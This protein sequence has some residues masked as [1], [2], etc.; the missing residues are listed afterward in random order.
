MSFLDD[1]PESVIS[2]AAYTDVYSSVCE[3]TC[4]MSEHED[5][6][7][8]VSGMTNILAF[9]VELISSADLRSFL[10]MRLSS[11]WWRCLFNQECVSC[12]DLKTVSSHAET[13]LL[14]DLNCGFNWTGMTKSSR[15]EAYERFGGRGFDC[16]KDVYLSSS[17]SRWL[18]LETVIIAQTPVLP[19][20][21]IQD[22]VCLYA[23]IGLS[24]QATDQPQTRLVAFFLTVLAS[25]FKGVLHRSSVSVLFTVS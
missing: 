15:N 9:C 13:N 5:D 7:D 10:E 23:S 24:S 14:A 25:R 11:K 12:S 6:R 17:I 22:A 4:E 21:E 2:D 16:C 3:L 18:V 8:S 1:W 19:H 20:P